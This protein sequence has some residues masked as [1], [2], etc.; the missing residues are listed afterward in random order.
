VRRC[1]GERVT[2]PPSVRLAAAEP[3]PDQ[4]ARL[5]TGVDILARTK[6]DTAWLVIE[7]K[8]GYPESALTWT[9]GDMAAPLNAFASN[10][11]NHHLLQAAWTAEAFIASTEG[12]DACDAC[13][14]RIRR[15][16]PAPKGSLGGR[17][18]H[19]ITVERVPG[20]MRA[21]VRSTLARE[22]LAAPIV[23]RMRKRVTKQAR[24][25]MIRGPGGA[26]LP[27]NLRL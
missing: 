6:N 8:T 3:W 10:I 7:V 1:T 13:V 2:E 15:P 26:L 23:D 12:V 18:A 14:L 25:G 21:A 19:S 17:I 22:R 4:V 27:R 11:R 24:R 9:C 16:P 5:A 20:A